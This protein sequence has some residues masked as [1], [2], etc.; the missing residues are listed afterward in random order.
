MLSRPYLTL[1]PSEALDQY[2]DLAIFFH[3]PPQAPAFFNTPT[4]DQ[5]SPSLSFL[6]SCV[7][8]RGPAAA[9]PGLVFA[10]W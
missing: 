6:L 3:C 4:P 2:N 7:Y 8:L 5:H 1:F 9:C 10:F